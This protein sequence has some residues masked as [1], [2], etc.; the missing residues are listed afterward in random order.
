MDEVFQPR[1]QVRQQG[2]TAFL[3]GLQEADCP[4]QE[5]TSAHIEWMSGYK[6]AKYGVPKS[7]ASRAA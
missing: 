1:H 6:D 2:E 3:R 4:Y 7:F 5:A